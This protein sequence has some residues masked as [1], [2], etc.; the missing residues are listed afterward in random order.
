[1]CI[2]KYSPGYSKA[3]DKTLHA[4]SIL[5]TLGFIIL[6]IFKDKF[7]M[8]L[9][10]YLENSILSMTILGF[11]YKYYGL[12]QDPFAIKYENNDFGFFSISV[13]F[14]PL[15]SWL[16]QIPINI[17]YID[18]ENFTLSDRFVLKVF[19]LFI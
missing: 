6:F 13:P 10:V 7:F 19:L 8:H 4:I 15:S 14:N 5:I 12:R 17:N 16:L 1:M 2:E 9:V 11:F 3:I 18:S